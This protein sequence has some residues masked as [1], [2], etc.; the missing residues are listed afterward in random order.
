M[1]P[2]MATAKALMPN[3]VPMVDDTVNSGAIRIPA[4]PANTP[5]SAKART[6]LALTSMP[7]SLAAS[8]FCTTASMALP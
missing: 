7:M 1:P 5:E 3:S 8:G 2:R 4:I 6:T